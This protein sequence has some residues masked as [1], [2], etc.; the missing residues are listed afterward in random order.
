[1]VWDCL[2]RVDIWTVRSN[3]EV[4]DTSSEYYPLSVT[5]VRSAFKLGSWGFA[6]GQLLTFWSWFHIPSA[7]SGRG[8]VLVTKLWKA[9]PLQAQSFFSLTR[10]FLGELYQVYQNVPGAKPASF[11]AL[12]DVVDVEVEQAGKT[13]HS[14]RTLFLDVLRLLEFWAKGKHPLWQWTAESR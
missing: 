11:K 9:A 2:N 13:S 6:T 12:L 5:C 1:M 7:Y 4:W 10:E 3:I 14:I 8:S